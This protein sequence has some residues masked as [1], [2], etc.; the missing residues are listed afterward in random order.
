MQ[1]RNHFSFCSH[2]RLVI[3][4]R[5]SGSSASIERRFEVGY[6]EADVVYRGPAARDEL[7]DWRIM[8]DGFQ[9]LHHRATS[10]EAADSRSVHC[11]KL[12]GAHPQHIPI[13]GKRVGDR[14]HRNAD[15]RNSN[16]LRG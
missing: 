4:Q 13:K 5:N 15:V 14:A 1:K 3:Y 9:E 7:A 11:G 10:I 12:R 2:T 6:L 8:I 16:T